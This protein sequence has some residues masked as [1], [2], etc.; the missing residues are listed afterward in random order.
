MERP[1]KKYVCEKCGYLGDTAEHEGCDYLACSTGEQLYIDHLEREL[2]LL[3]ASLAWTTGEQLC[4][5][6]L[7][8]EL[9]LLKASPASAPEGFTM[10][11]PTILPDGSGFGTMSFPL[12]KDRWIYKE[13]EYED[14]AIE[15]NDLPVPILTHSFRR[16]VIA[17]IRYAVRSA[18]NCG[19][20]DDFDPDALVQNAVYA[21]C[22]PYGKAAPTPPVSESVDPVMTKEEL[23]AA[24]ES[25]GMRFPGASIPPVSEDR[26]LPIETAPKDEFVLLAG[27]SGYTTIETVF[28]TGRMC[29]DYHVGRWIDHANDDL[30]DWGFEPTH[31]RPL[32]KAPTMQEDKP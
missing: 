22:G 1:P 15:P 18:T 13:R 24:A 17:A 12:P 21:L 9:A 11:E 3:K 32:P 7:E 4:I 28:S 29:S 10:S 8:R 30:T 16:Q 27:P 14:G 2:A 5:D 20:E 25:I 6:Q 31:W 23:I 26:W 19:K